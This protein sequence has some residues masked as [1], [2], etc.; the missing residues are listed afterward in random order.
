MPRRLARP[1]LVGSA[2]LLLPA[3]VG[4]G[5]VLLKLD[6][7]QLFSRASWRLP[8]RVVANLRLEPG[9]RVADIGA[10]DGYFTFF[11]ADAVGPDGKVFAIDV[12]RNTIAKLEKAVEN[13]GYRNIE[14]VLAETGDPSLPDG[15]IDLAFVCNVYHH[16]DDQVTYFDRLRTDLRAGGRLAIVE[17]GEALAFRLLTPPGHW[18][19]RTTLREELR[20][21]HYLPAHSFDFLPVQNFEIF[22]PDSS[23]PEPR[24]S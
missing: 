8:D 14:V 17:M 10:G 15:S 3:A 5:P 18:T 2:L 13:R 16:I 4:F 23:A 20:R 6:Y 1:L 11:L 12:D 7:G 19:A 21:A 22:M 24:G 9:A